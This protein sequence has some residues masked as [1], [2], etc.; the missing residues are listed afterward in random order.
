MITQGL[1]PSLDTVA[2]VADYGPFVLALIAFLETFFVTGIFVPTSVAI[3]AAMVLVDEGALDLVTVAFAA[4]AGGF[5]GDVTGYWIGRLG[6]ERLRTSGGMV[7]RS[8]ARFDREGGRFVSGHPLF[9][10]TFARLVAF[11]R[12]FMPMASGISRL[13]FAVFVLYEIPGLLAWFALYAAIGAA[14]DEGIE[15]AARVMGVGW[16]VV[17]AV[18][19]L[20]LWTRAR[21]RRGRRGHP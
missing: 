11:V 3:A 4:V 7:G 16:L 15:Q 17:F 13:P 6:G 12:T 10:V 8:F 21:R 14:A 19:G 20:L 9:T 5:I 2:L 18:A 1:A